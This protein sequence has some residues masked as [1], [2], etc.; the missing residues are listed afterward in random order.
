MRPLL[1][2]ERRCGDHLLDLWVAP[3]QRRDPHLVRSVPRSIT[4]MAGTRPGTRGRRAAGPGAALRLG[5]LERG[6]ALELRVGDCFDLKDPAAETIGD[7]TALPCTELHEYEIF[8]VGSMSMAERIYPSQEELDGYVDRYCSP[9]FYTY[10]GK[11][12]AE[13]ELEIFSLFPTNEGWGDGDRSVSC[14]AHL[15][16]GRLNA[17]VKGSKR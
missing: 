17:S 6:A 14:A 7:V 12:Y 9:T 4:W 8:F 3:R 13:S 5:R 1:D 11:I 10:V 16:D 15:G 2:G